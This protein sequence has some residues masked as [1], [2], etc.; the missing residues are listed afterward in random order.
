[1]KKGCFG[2]VVAN[3]LMGVRRAHGALLLGLLLLSLLTPALADSEEISWQPWSD[4]ILAEARAEGRLVF[5][6]GTSKACPWCRKMEAG[7]F[8]D[9]GVR[10]LIAQSFLPVRV[11]LR[12]RD[13]VPARFQDLQPPTLLVL[14]ADGGEMFFHHGYLEAQELMSALTQALG[15]R[16]PSRP[17]P[18]GLNGMPS[19][20]LGLNEAAFNLQLIKARRG[21]QAARAWLV[22]TLKHVA[23]R[24]DPVWGGVFDLGTAGSYKKTLSDQ[25]VAGWIFLAGGEAFDDSACE[26]DARDTARYVMRFLKGDRGLFEEQEGVISRA[27]AP[28]DYFRLD[29]QDRRSKGLPK[30]STNRSIAGSALMM[31]RMAELY[32]VSGEGQFLEYAEAIRGSLITDAERR[33]N[34]ISPE[35]SVAMARGFLAFY[36]VTADRKLL[37][38]SSQSF[39]TARRVYRSSSGSQISGGSSADFAR[40]ALLLSRYTGDESLQKEGRR[41]VTKLEAS[42]SDRGG[43]PRIVEA[44]FDAPRE[45]LHIVVV[46]SKRDDQARQLWSEAIQLVHPFLRREWW[47][48]EEGPLPNP[49]ISYPLLTRPAA[50]L[51]FER[52]CSLPLFT[53]SELQAKL[54]EAVPPL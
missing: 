1:M 33:K 10:K 22:Q 16:T 20:T 6:S 28:A 23:S 47:D 49:D 14:A 51:C 9:K 29:D 15:K 34:E 36:S 11:N 42:N 41:I 30:V 21:D 52:R 53:R 27:G 3:A 17:G 7:A 43:D 19:F 45:P 40:T 2:T 31:A 18:A 44:L 54:Q 38:S 48:R 24:H 4:E 26:Q 12:E 32:G 50:F 46:G 13:E 25:V 8:E 5:V 35:D 37:T 39:S